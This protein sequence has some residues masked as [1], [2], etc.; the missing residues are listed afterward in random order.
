VSG[1]NDIEGKATRAGASEHGQ[2]TSFK[3]RLR[4]SDGRQVANESKV[5][6]GQKILRSVLNVLP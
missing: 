6:S 5:F 2:R 3:I 1:T 4:K